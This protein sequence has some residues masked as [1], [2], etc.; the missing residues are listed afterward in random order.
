MFCAISHIVLVSYQGSF[1]RKY[2]IYEDNQKLDIN[3]NFNLLKS[4]FS[5]I[6]FLLSLI[7]F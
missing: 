2:S 5:L 6:F 1:N 3:L 4:F 7:F